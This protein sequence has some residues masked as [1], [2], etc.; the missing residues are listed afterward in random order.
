MSKFKFGDIVK[1]D[2]YGIGVVSFV[3]EGNIDFYVSWKDG[4]EFS[5]W[6]LQDELDLIKHPDT[7]RLDW[8]AN[9]NT[10][11]GQVLLPKECVELNL[12]DMRAAID[13]AMQLEKS[14]QQH[15][16]QQETP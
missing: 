2:R 10:K 3:K 6:I 8:L 14:E 5:C 13:M 16:Q 1:N 4:K 11:T 12:H 9:L 7:R 15:G